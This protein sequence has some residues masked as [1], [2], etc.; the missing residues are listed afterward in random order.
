MS[1]EPVCHQVPHDHP[2]TQKDI[3]FH[4]S[5]ARK[6]MPWKTEDSTNQIKVKTVK[7]CKN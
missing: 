3:V 4:S 1:A 2:W 5:T 6:D 7:H